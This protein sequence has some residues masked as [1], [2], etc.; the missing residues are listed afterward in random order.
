MEVLDGAGSPPAGVSL[1]GQEW[2]AEDGA[3]Q[4]M[5][6]HRA[7]M[8]DQFLAATRGDGFVGM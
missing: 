3:D 7:A 2:I 6:A 4:E 8:E 5:A 1:V